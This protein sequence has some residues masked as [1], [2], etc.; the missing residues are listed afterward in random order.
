MADIADVEQALVDTINSNLYP[1]GSSQPSI[2]G[3]QCRIY[4]GWP[5]SATLNNDLNAGTVNVTVV[6]DNDTGVT[7]T[8]YLPVWKSTP[9]LP[10]VSASVAGE[11]I[12]I[13][14][15]PTKGDLVGALVDRRA[16]VYRV[17]SEDTPDLVAAN[18]SLM[19]QANQPAAVQWSTITIPGAASIM[20]RTVADNTTLFESRR[21][22]KNF[23]IICWC[24]AP[25]V[26]DTIAATIDLGLNQISFLPLPDQTNARIT[27]RD[28]ASYDQSQNAQ[29][30]R[31]DL[32]YMGE[33]PTVATLQQPS[34]LFGASAIN[35]NITYG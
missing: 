31:R 9:S 18:L 19:I 20:V 1:A 14:G 30:Y 11:T 16:Y 13:S 32:V 22:Q 35:G 23:R 27:Y 4:R 7:T 24:P 26:R 33:Y 17:Q 15:T 8:R 12:V 3:A 2:V 21:Q 29:L 34:M 6:T 10:G 25:L 28:S 5:N